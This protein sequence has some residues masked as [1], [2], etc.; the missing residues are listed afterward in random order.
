MVFPEWIPLEERADRGQCDAEMPEENLVFG[1]TRRVIANPK[2]YEALGS[3]EFI[4][5][6]S[7]GSG[8]KEQKRR[9]IC[10]V[11]KSCRLSTSNAS[12]AI[13]P[14]ETTRPA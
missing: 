9:R 1:S 4:H 13:T 5:H 14:A 6:A 2:R 3:G 8:Q 11:L 7:M 12:P 10:S